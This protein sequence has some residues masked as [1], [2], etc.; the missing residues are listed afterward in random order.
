[1]NELT[2]RWSRWRRRCVP[3]SD[4]FRHA[5]FSDYRQE[6][7]VR[8]ISPH[9]D[10]DLGAEA[11]EVQMDENRRLGGWRSAI[12][13]AATLLVGCSGEPMGTSDE[14]AE[15]RVFA[16]TTTGPMSVTTPQPLPLNQITFTITT[17]DAPLFLGTLQINGKAVPASGVIGSVD[18]S[19]ASPQA[20]AFHVF[21]MGNKFEQI[22][23]FVYT[24]PGVLAIQITYDPTTFLAYDLN[25]L[26]H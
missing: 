25:P 3:S 24:H 17:P 20:P 9:S 5:D 15:S 11:K 21:R 10:T 7:R 22:R 13:A 12:V 18:P 26:T 14:Q 1:M 4:S 23:Q 2:A 19:G 8:L 6:R 16:L